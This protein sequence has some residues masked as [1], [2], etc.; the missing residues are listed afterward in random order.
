MI[1]CRACLEG[2]GE[3]VDR[4]CLRCHY[5]LE[6]CKKLREEAAE[7]PLNNDIYADPRVQRV[8]EQM[9]PTLN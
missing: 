7:A 2:T 9:M 1:T 3:T 8:I 5:I 4:L 6:E